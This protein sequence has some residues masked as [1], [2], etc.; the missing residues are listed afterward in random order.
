MNDD[1]L[2]EI[3]PTTGPAF[4]RE[5]AEKAHARVKELEVAAIHLLC[6]WQRA[7]LAAAVTTR[8]VERANREY[9]RRLAVLGIGEGRR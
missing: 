9:R 3:G 2:L 1:A 7:A 6:E 4:W 8:D 5:R